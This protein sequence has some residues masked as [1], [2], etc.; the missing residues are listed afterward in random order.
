M[1]ILFLSSC[2]RQNRIEQEYYVTDV[3]V[4]EFLTLTL[5]IDNNGKSKS[6]QINQSKTT[7]DNQKMIDG[8]IQKNKD[9]V[10]PLESKLNGMCF[11]YTYQFVN[12]KYERKIKNPSEC[13]NFDEFKTGDFKYESILYPN[14]LVKRN[15]SLQVETDGKSKFVY[16]IAWKSDCEY[17]LTYKEVNNPKFDY[18]IGKTIHVKIIEKL[19]HDSY[20][21]HSNLLNRTNGTGIMTKI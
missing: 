8:I 3:N 13:Q 9:I 5:C 11:D 15:D 17:A 16:S 4:V 20:L 1:F 2:N 6:I 14:V 21:Y 18:L 12:K 7:Y 10:Y 19:T